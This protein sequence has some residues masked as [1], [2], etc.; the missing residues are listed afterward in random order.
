MAILGKVINE[1]VEK[2]KEKEEH[3]KRE[4]SLFREYFELIAE[5]AVFVFFVMTYVVQAFQIPTGS[6]EPTLM[7]GDFLLVNKF[8]YAKP[9]IPLEAAIL[10]SKK[11]ERKDIV[12]FKYPR[13]LKKDYVKRVVALEGEKIEI[14][15][16]EVFINDRPLEE[17]YK[18][19]IDA[20]VFQKNGYYQYD[21][22]IRDNYGPVVVPPGHVFV[23]GDNRD[24]SLDSRYWG[25]LPM[26]YIKGRPWLIYF[27]YE[28]ERDAYLK[29]GIQD[30]FKKFFRFFSK[31]RW[32]RILKVV[33]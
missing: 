30:K 14:K 28:A 21:D 31:T 16:K 33:N 18:V 25:F 19:H 23:M 29:N 10:P 17:R 2:I 27:S 9:V 15:D 8:I 22:V 24:N 3:K 13:D 20:Q 32:T 5:T 12:V 7:V 26:N 6:M 11:I 1:E 4:K